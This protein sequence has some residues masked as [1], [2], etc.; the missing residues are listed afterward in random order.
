MVDSVYHDFAHWIASGGLHLNAWHMLASPGAAEILARSPFDS[1]TIDMQHGQSSVADMMAA[2]AGVAAA[3]KPAL[4]RVPVGDYS[5]AA[6]ALDAGAR[7]IICP[8]IQTAADARSLAEATKFPPTGRRSWGPHRALAMSQ[9]TASEFLHEENSR[10]CIFAMIETEEALGNLNAIVETTG[11]DGVFVG[12]NDL[13][14]SLTA[15]REISVEH[16]L[17]RQACAA[18]AE[19]A[20]RHGKHAGIYANTPALAV[21]Y[22]ALGFN[23]IAIGSDIGFLT[24]QSESAVSAVR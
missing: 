9:F 11:I 23:F 7:G 22:K 21:E 20:A 17:V 1:V 12:P 24:S 3:G 6:R 18:I 15:G 16:P 19:T 13:C 2:I 8:M 10:N 5:L 4:V 14:V